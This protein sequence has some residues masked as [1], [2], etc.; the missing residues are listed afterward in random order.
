MEERALSKK[1]LVTGGEGYY[2]EKRSKF[3]GSSFP[4]KNEA[5]A[6]KII[7]ETKK[8]YCD[9]RHNCFAYITEGI[10]RSSDDGEPSGTAG[11]PILAVLEGEDLDSVLVTVTRYFGGILLGGGGL[12][13]AYTAAAKD[14]ISH[15]EISTLKLCCSIRVEADYPSFEKFRRMSGNAGFSISEEEYSE[16]V[17]FTVKGPTGDRDDI[18]RILTDISGGNAGIISEQEIYTP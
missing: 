17:A 9:A 12:V 4:V 10:K 2:E 3:I 16:K 13:R 6:L 5:E 14:A 8:K 15:S 18:V 11:R 1:I 7:S